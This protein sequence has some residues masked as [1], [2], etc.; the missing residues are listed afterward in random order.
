MLGYWKNPELTAS[1]TR[2]DYIILSDLGYMGDDGLL[3]FVGRADDIIISGSYKIA[4]L[5]IEETANSFDGI[6][7]SAC[8]PVSDPIMGQI[9]KLYVVMEE[10]H[11]FNSNK[12]YK[13]LQDKLEMTRVPRIIEEINEIPKINNKINRRELKNR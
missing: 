3:Y 1:V 5:E 9:P 4:P 6:R 8:V 13:F 10:N 2:G 7:E 11:V 12:I